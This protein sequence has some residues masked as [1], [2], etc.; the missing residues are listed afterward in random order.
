[1]KASLKHKW[2][3][4]LRSGDYEQTRILL[5]RVE[6]SCSY[7]C[8]GVL[9]DVIDPTKW[10]NIDNS[11]CSRYVFDDFGIK[12]DTIYDAAIMPTSVS[13]ALGLDN[14]HRI[15]I[16]DKDGNFSHEKEFKTVDLLMRMN[17][18]DRKSFD[19][20]ADWIEETIPEE[21]D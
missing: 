21:D 13:V 8:I 18:E 4:A 1:M 20:I 7:C 19:Q 14:I 17:D 16:Y 15:D 10:T 2:L 3:K 5:K 6:P 11:S 12:G 9:C